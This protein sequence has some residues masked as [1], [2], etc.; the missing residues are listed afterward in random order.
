[1]NTNCV[2]QGFLHYPNIGMHVIFLYMVISSL[3]TAFQKKNVKKQ[4]TATSITPPNES[5]ILLNREVGRL[6][7][8]TIARK[9]DDQ[10]I[11]TLITWPR[12]TGKLTEICMKN[13]IHKIPET[14]S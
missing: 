8:T 6:R 9:I 5:P 13:Q 3:V 11:I 14:I 10:M 2:Q 7:K 1:M 12:I 4:P